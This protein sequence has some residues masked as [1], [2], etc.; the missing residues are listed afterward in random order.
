MKW[1]VTIYLCGVAT[2]LLFIAC[3]LIFSERER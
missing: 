1:Y 3:V 2:G